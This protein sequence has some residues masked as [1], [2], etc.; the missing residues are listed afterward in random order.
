MRGRDCIAS[1]KRWGRRDA[2][3][4]ELI[5]RVADMT[6]DSDRV[7]TIKLSRPFPKML[8][9]F[10]KVTTSC[11]FIMPERLANVDPFTNISEAV[12]SGP[13]RFVAE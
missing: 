1:I 8:E 12:G 6:E 3:G 9:A 11:L 7:F 2:F 5:A 4:Q 13:F 10:S